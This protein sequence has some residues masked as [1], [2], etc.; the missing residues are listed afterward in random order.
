MNKAEFILIV[1]GLLGVIF[2]SLVK[3][4]RLYDL[5]K[6]A[7]IDFSL[8]RDYLKGDFVSILLSFTSVII[9]F[10]IFGEVATNWQWLT[11]FPR[12]SF[13]CMGSFGS[14]CIQYGLGKTQKMLERIIDQRTEQL[15]ESQKDK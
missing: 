10:L 3:M 11:T 15:I 6:R 1:C 14:Y 12:F 9:W 7:Q 4:N 13:F 5:A 8:Y 2:H